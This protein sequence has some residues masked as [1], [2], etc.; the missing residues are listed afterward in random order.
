ML[1]QAGELRR[2]EWLDGTFGH[3]DGAGVD[4]VTRI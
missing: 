2:L 1:S 3:F 4:G